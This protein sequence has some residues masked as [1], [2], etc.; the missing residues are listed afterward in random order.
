MATLKVYDLVPGG[1]DLVASDYNLDNSDSALTLAD[2]DM[3]DF[4]NNGATFLLVKNGDTAGSITFPHISATAVTIAASTDYVFGPFKPRSFS[5]SSQPVR[6]TA[7][8][9]AGK[10]NN[11][12]ITLGTPTTIDLA[13]FRV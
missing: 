12:N 2:G 8:A 5:S 3:H 7:T 1:L 13:V 4:P 11:V 9:R 6:S 10:I